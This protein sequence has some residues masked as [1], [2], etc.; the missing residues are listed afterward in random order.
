MPTEFLEIRIDKF[1]FKVKKDYFYSKANA[2]AQLEDDLVRVGITDFKQQTIGDVAFVEFSPDDNRL[3]P[4][5]ELAQIETIKVISDVLSPISGTLYQVNEELEVSPELINEDPYGRGWLA[6]IKPRDW[7]TD[8]A[9]LLTAEAYL[10]A[11]RYQAEEE[12]KK[13]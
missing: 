9:N 12:M 2:W 8:R 7:D 10:E 3:S 5:S 4:D 13:R 1:V 6:F 11:I